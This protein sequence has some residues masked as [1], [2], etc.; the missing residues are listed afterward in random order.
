MDE[1]KNFL[2]VIAKS[3]QKNIGGRLSYHSES[4]YLD[5]NIGFNRAYYSDLAAQIS[6]MYVTEGNEENLILKYNLR[7]VDDF[8][9][10]DLEGYKLYFPVEY[11]FDDT[12]IKIPID[13]FNKTKSSHF[14]IITEA[15]DVCPFNGKEFNIILRSA[16]INKIKK[17]I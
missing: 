6:L 9:E 13:E 3:I 17:L 5:I 4:Y 11:I 15:L 2:E 16:K 10:Y 7:Y 12:F 8:D 1:R 14:Q